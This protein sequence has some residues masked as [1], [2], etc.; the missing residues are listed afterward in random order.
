MR[1]I[2]CTTLYS[3]IIV[4]YVWNHDFM[5]VKTHEFFFQISGIYVM[6]IGIYVMNMRTNFCTFVIT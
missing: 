4:E 2:F 3:R 6:H 1:H 5:L